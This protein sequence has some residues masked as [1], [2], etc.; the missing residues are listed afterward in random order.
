MD[1]PSKA[2]KRFARHC[3]DSGLLEYPEVQIKPFAK[4]WDMFTNAELR[5]ERE[6]AEEMVVVLVALRSTRTLQAEATSI[7]KKIDEVV[8]AYR[9]AQG[10]E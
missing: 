8:A 6:A 5:E 1:E 3:L 10:R 9:K 7:V 2:A 4:A